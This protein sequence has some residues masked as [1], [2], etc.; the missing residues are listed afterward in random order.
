MSESVV[1]KF[2]RY[3]NSEGVV[4]TV[5][6]SFRHSLFL[7]RVSF[8]ERIHNDFDATF[9][10]KTGGTVGVWRLRL[11][12]RSKLGNRYQ[13]VDP[14]AFN[15]AMNLLQID[16][17]RFTFVDLGCGKGRALLLASQYGFK[18][19]IG[20]EYSPALLGIAA[21]NVATIKKDIEIVHEDASKYIFPKEPLVVFL[22]DPFR[23][24]VLRETILNLCASLNQEEG[25]V[26]YVNCVDEKYFVQ[27]GCFRELASW[28]DAKIYQHSGH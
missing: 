20:V 22:F 18:R 2:M 11:G 15:R 24:D 5:Q 23:G 16:F 19:I 21:K 26:V 8:L 13:P 9:R 10:T 4:K 3:L 12:S 1:A 14:R 7:F 25:Y 27:R 28:R 6:R 17:K